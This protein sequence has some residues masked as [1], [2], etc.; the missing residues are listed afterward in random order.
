ME[1]YLARL[2]AAL[3]LGGP[4]RSALRARVAQVLGRAGLAG[5]DLPA[6][7]Q[8]LSQAA[9]IVHDA[10]DREV[11]P[12]AARRLARGWSGAQRVETDGLGHRR[13]LRNPDVVARVTAFVA[14]KEESAAAPELAPPT[15]RLASRR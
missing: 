4:G 3:D 1:P 7:T 9:L 6:L 11:P 14:A 12:A 5:F 15:L 2:D 10:G 8:R 13:L